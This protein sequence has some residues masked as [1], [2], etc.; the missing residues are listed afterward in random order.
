MRAPPSIRSRPATGICVCSAWQSSF[1]W[2]AVGE[3]RDMLLIP[4][5]LGDVAC[6]GFPRIATTPELEAIPQRQSQRHELA[7]IDPFEHA[8]RHASG[9]R[10]DMLGAD[11]GIGLPATRGAP[12]G[13]A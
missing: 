4:A 5:D 7:E 6:G 10:A 2:V 11:E 9:Q 13:P 12:A 8:R 1:R 3:D